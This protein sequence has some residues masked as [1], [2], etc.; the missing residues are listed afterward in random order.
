MP[1]IDALS[2]P[3]PADAVGRGI[4]RTCKPGYNQRSMLADARG[5]DRT[6][7]SGPGGGLGQGAGFLGFCV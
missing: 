2:V 3:E 4:F 6:H 5:R 1:F 7:F